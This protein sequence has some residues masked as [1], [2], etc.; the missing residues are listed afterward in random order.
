[1]FGRIIGISGVVVSFVAGGMTSASAQSNVALVIGNSHYQHAAPLPT[2]AADAAVIAET[3]RAAGYDVTPAN[4]VRQ[5][6]FS[7]LLRIFLGKLAAGGNNATGFFYY[8]GYAAQSDGQNYLVP[9]DAS[10]TNAGDV[11]S[12]AFRLGELVDAFA[13]TP[14]GARIVVLD[15]SYAH[16]FG[17]GGAQPVPPGLAPMSA[18]AGMMIASA[19]GPGEVAGV[20]SGN[21]LFTHM[22]S[23]LAR[24]PG[25]GLDRVFMTVSGRV[26]QATNGGQT[27]WMTSALTTDV[28]LFAMPQPAAPA[29]APAPAA[30]TAPAPAVATAPTPAVVSAP[31]APPQAEE[32]K[33]PT[34]KEKQHAAERS[35]PR[36]AA[37]TGPAESAPDAP[38]PSIPL[39]I[40]I[41][42]VGIGIGGIGIGIGR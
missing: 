5:S 31:A 4:D 8:A 18:P 3:L 12:Q 17:S 21:S 28:T 38:P 27:P 26:N 1:M 14:A 9:V 2:T 6:D 34:K 36:K 42:G 20:A 11:A 19:A 32:A 16:G 37:R 39:S 41:G 40:G 22:V 33:Q 10:I 23:R 30:A 35:R 29:A 25:L 15:A 7:L 24:L 13:G